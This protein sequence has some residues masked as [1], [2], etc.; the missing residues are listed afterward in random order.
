MSTIKSK[1]FLCSLSLLLVSTMAQAIPIDNS[2]VSI[3]DSSAA[4]NATYGVSNVLDTG[5]NT[6][7]ASSNGGV[8]TFIEF[9]LGTMVTLDSIIYTDRVTSGVGQGICCGTGF[10]DFVTGS[11]K[12]EIL[13]TMS[14]VTPLPLEKSLSILRI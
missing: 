5:V 7:F 9:D 1:L 8:N 10:G 6:D 4:F 13:M 12:S 2:T 14:S 3:T 11:I